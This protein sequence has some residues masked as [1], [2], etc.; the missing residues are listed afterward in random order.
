[1][2]HYSKMKRFNLKIWVGNEAQGKE[3]QGQSISAEA[4]IKWE[5]TLQ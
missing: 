4:V 3:G 5:F 1:M 2:F